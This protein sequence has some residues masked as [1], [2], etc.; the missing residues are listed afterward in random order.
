MENFNTAWT[1][2]NIL[3]GIEL[4]SEDFEDIGLIAWNRIGNKQ[5]RLYRY[6]VDV[7]CADQEVK[8]PCNCDYIESI[9]TMSEDWNEITDIHPYGGDYSSQYTESYIEGLKRNKNPFYSSGKY[10]KYRQ[11]GNNLYF[12]EPY[13]KLQIIYKGVEADE[14]GLPYIN[15]KEK[16]A[17]ACFCAYI[18][19]FKEGLASHNQ[20][21]L[22]EAQMLEQKWL[23]LCD[24]ARVSER[25]SQNEMDQILDARTNWNRKSYGKSYKPLR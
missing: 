24:A 14:E 13:G 18:T 15:E 10:V 2:A 5:T 11:V 20:M 6:I 21:E 19:K 3:Y 16:D 17:I 22:Q 9:T 23:K 1:Y 7:N 12:D 8:L 4:D 25:I